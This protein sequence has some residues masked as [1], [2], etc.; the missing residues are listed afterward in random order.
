LDGQWK[1]KLRDIESDKVEAINDLEHKM[2]NA[3]Q[4]WTLMK[5]RLEGE[6]R[7]IEQK[8]NNEL[9]I[10][11]DK[12]LSTVSSKDGMIK[13]LNERIASLESAVRERELMLDRHRSLLE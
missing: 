4:E 6:Q 8:Y 1:Q 10:I 7:T 2:R 5:N 12:V 9:S 3:E 13:Q 11:S